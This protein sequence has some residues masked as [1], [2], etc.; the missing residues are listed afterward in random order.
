VATSRRQSFV[1][2]INTRK[3][4]GKHTRLRIEVAP[5]PKNLYLNTYIH[6][7][8][9]RLIRPELEY[10]ESIKTK[11]FYKRLQ[12][13][14]YKKTEPWAMEDLRA[15]LKSLKN[16]KTRDPHDLIN[17]LFKPENIGSDMEYSLLLLLNKIMKPCI[18]FLNVC[19]CSM[20]T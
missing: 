9:H 20:P 18:H 19:I 1:T 13:V 4:H 11:L 17:E 15:I 12:L 16:N 14:K 5:P 10:L 7:L 6:R 2:R 3:T 8:R